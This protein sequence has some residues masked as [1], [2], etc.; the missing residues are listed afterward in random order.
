MDDKK[1]TATKKKWY[2]RWWI[3]VIALVLIIIAINAI[4]KMVKNISYELKPNVTFTVEEA[5]GNRT[6]ST[7]P[8]GIYDV[9]IIKR[10]NGNYIVGT[11]RK[12]SVTPEQAYIVFDIEL[13]DKKG[14]PTVSQTLDTSILDIYSSNSPLLAYGDVYEF[15]I[16]L[17]SKGDNATQFKVFKLEEIGLD[18]YNSNKINRLLSNA[19]YQIKNEGFD[20]ARNY[21]D[22]ALSIDPDNGDV[23]ALYQR[24]EQAEEDAQNRE[25]ETVPPETSPDTPTDGYTYDTA[26]GE[27]ISPP[28][29]LTGD[30]AKELQ[31]YLDLGYTPVTTE[32]LCDGLK[33]YLGSSLD[34][35]LIHE[36]TVLGFGND[37]AMR[38]YV[39][40]KE[41]VLGT[42]TWIRFSAIT[43]GIMFVAGN[44]SFD[45]GFLTYVIDLNDPALTQ[46][47][48]T[49]I[50]TDD[51]NYTKVESFSL[52]MSV[53]T[54]DRS[55]LTMR[56]YGIVTEVKSPNRAEIMTTSG[57]TV[58]HNL[59]TPTDMPLYTEK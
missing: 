26:T 13:Y 53:Y 33:I 34:E 40:V 19:E 46:A 12:N 48:K 52:L 7:Q 8:L 59:L 1:N 56:P 35:D 30:S 31:R 51:D 14:T 57:Q 10:S 47:K 24:L 45:D 18:Y 15:E 20:T 55:T 27:W 41:V 44:G 21:L 38:G 28:D 43:E 9:Q 23:L 29:A 36:Y 37:G 49:V 2:Q 16:P 39:L 32:H 3:W 11:I 6:E 4:S 58:S 50:K 54:F 17:Y 42:E 25:T 22:E 5:Y